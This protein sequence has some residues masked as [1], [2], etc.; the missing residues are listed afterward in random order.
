MK[1][2][3]IKAHNVFSIGDIEMNLGNRG[4]TLVTGWSYDD[5]NGNAAGKSSLARNAITWGM[6]G[7]TVDGVKADAVINT[8]IK[9]AKH[10]GVTL[11]FEGV[12]GNTYRIYRARRPNSLVLSILNHGA[13]EDEEEWQDLSQRLEKDTQQ[14]VDALLGRD[15]KTFIQANFFGQGREQSFLALPGSEQRAVIEEILPLSSLEAWHVN[16]SEGKKKAQVKVEAARSSRM[17]QRERVAMASEHYEGLKS[18]QRAWDTAKIVELSGLQHKL[19][20]IQLMSSGIEEE[21]A[22]LMQAL[23]VQPLEESFEQYREEERRLTALNS[24]LGHKIDELTGDIDVRASRPEVCGLCNQR[25]PHAAIESNKICVTTAKASRDIHVKERGEVEAKRYNNDAQLAI[26]KEVRQLEMTL[27]MRSHEDNLKE[28]L[29]LVEEST[30]PF[31]TVT[32]VALDH[33]KEEMRVDDGLLLLLVREEVSRDHY[34]FWDKAFGRDLK[35]LLFDQVCPYLE[36]RTNKYLSDLNNG[37]IKV[38]FSV[39]KELKCGDNRDQFSVT[40]SSSTGSKAFELFSG[41]EKQLTSF[42]VGMALSDLAGLQTKGATKFMILD[43]PFLY[44][45]PQNCEAI[46]S[47]L[48]TQKAVGDSTILLISNED[49]LAGLIPNRV[50]VVKR[51][52]VSSIE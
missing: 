10:C 38:R 2:L 5:N 52:G 27:N 12:D 45:S 21:M 11:H 6:Y 43:E 1:L 47:F 23:P 25:L 32:T 35:T 7:K 42:A 51:N 41:A 24:T 31:D 37:Q 36:Q 3:N 26:C 29:R 34:Y 20:K 15:H 44:Q 50:H 49:N 46:V 16:A 9:N 4:L 17:A 19:N 30:N 13:L 8:S 33:R 28:R 40:A 39:I 22:A 48:T 14:I 18:Q